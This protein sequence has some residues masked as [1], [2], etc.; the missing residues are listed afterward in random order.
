MSLA[1]VLAL[2]STAATAQGVWVTLPDMPAPHSVLASTAAKCP[3]G[4][5]GTCVYAVS[6][7]DVGD[8]Q[9]LEAYSPASGTWVTLPAPKFPR[10]DPATTTAPCPGGVKGDCVYAI[11]GVGGGG[12]TLNTVEAYSTKTNVWLTV[13]SMP[14]GRADTAA[15]TAPCPDELGLRGTCVYVFGGRAGAPLATVE[16]FSPSTNTWATLAPLQAARQTHGGA[17]APCP[18]DL[19]LHG[20]CVYAISGTGVP[21]LLPSVEV[22]S[23][24]LGQWQYAADIPTPRADFGAAA[25]PC[26]EG[27]SNGCVYTVGGSSGVD[28]VM[29]TFEAYTP[30]AN[31]WAS[32]PP[33]PTARVNL[34]AATAPCPGDKHSH[35]VYALG[36]PTAEVTS[37]IAEAFVIEGGHSGH[38]PKPKP[39]AKPKPDHKPKPEPD[40][41]PKPEH[42]PKPEP[43][44]KPKPE[45]E[46][47]PKPG[48][49]HHDHPEG[50]PGHQAEPPLDPSA[51]ASQE[52]QWFRGPQK[53]QEQEPRT[54]PAS[55]P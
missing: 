41:K 23:P 29:N 11:G 55:A 48:H 37:A 3:E 12:A 49:Q 54:A 14:T 15:A 43:E 28:A 17:A 53:Q 10:Y 19:H 38:K 2:A 24:S 42:K 45:P 52:A 13:R 4:L 51:D 50:Q 39:E 6:A 1:P 30:A 7:V 33:L 21:G 5:H 47:K 46:H 26:P 22:Y 34:G 25:A 35:C 18:A 27:M 44:H 16:A 31:A 36:G 8:R 40:A 32:L 20:T 9:K